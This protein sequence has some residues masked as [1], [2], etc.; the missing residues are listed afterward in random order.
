[1]TTI[2]TATESPLEHASIAHIAHGEQRQN[3]MSMARSAYTSD[4]VFRLD[5]DAVF[6]RHWLFAG[7][8]ADIPEP[9][10][11]RVVDVAGEQ[12][13]IW[14]DRDR[15]IRAHFNVCRHRGSRLT[16]ESC[17][18]AASLKCPYHQWTYRPDGSLAG[19]RLMGDGFRPDDYPLVGV[20]LRDLGGLLFVC[21][22]DDPPPFDAAMDAIGPQIAPHGLDHAMVVRREVYDVAANW[23]T[24]VENNRECYHCRVSHPEFTL[25]N[26]DVGLPG[27]PRM[28][29]DYQRKLDEA[30]RRWRELGLAPETVSFPHG[31]WFRIARMPLKDGFATETADGTLAAP[32]M[33]ALGSAE[34]G[35]LRII[36]LPNFWAHANA[37]YASTTQLDP[38]GANRTRVE[39]CFLVSADAQ[40]GV[41]C[42]VD[43][44]AAVLQQTFEQD[45]ELCESV[46]AG[47]S[48]RGWRPGPYSPIVEASVQTFNS[49]YLNQL[50]QA[51]A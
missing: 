18:N 33:G 14:R 45:I 36:G 15:G 6:G 21:L 48:S 49:W 29:A 1:M 23:K 10:D 37:D 27:D 25:A 41:N 3:G 8:A 44:L 22:S 4:E 30:T 47:L 32:L 40:P 7:H 31:E 19:A 13:I 9:G 11:F 39:V 2:T 34:V 51:A 28:P 43:K 16:W 50:S 46:S 20:A 26:Y 5:L 12:V 42:D 17:G 35:S 24:L 38:L